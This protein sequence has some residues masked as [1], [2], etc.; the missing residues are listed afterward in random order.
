M[1]VFNKTF[2]DVKQGFVNFQFN[3][4]CQM[5]IDIESQ[6][7]A[8]RVLIVNVGKVYDIKTNVVS[9]EFGT[10]IEHLFNL[11]N[12]MRKKKYLIDINFN[13]IYWKQTN[14]KNKHLEW[15]M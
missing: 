12:K 3:L 8:K 15:I 6:Q 5:R 10:F 4:L 1:L 9:L 13:K 11:F 2:V 14:K 7:I